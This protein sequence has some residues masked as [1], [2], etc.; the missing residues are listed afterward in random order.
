MRKSLAAV[1]DSPWAMNY[2][3]FNFRIIEKLIDMTCRP[4]RLAAWD[5]NCLARPARSR[6]PQRRGMQIYVTTQAGKKMTVNV[7]APDTINNVLGHIQDREGICCANKSLMMKPGSC[8]SM[9]ELEIMQGDELYLVDD[10]PCHKE[11]FVKLPTG[12]TIH[13]TDLKPETT[14]ESIKKTIQRREGI[15]RKC[16][17]RLTLDLHDGHTLS[18]Y[19]TPGFAY[20]VNMM[21][22]YDTTPPI[23]SIGSVERRERSV[24]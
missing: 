13:L 22:V 11:M 16:P 4:D 23:E 8:F 24:L 20:N 5:R 12:N 17:M 2:V 14:I 18:D 3:R 1:L 15:G 9:A 7:E 21:P 6:T 10:L 19:T